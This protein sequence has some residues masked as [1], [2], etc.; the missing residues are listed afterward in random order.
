MKLKS[1]RK[2]VFY[3]ANYESRLGKPDIIIETNEPEKAWN[4]IRLANTA[5]KNNQAIKIFFISAGVEI[6]QITGVLMFSA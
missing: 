1:R 6:E 3:W 2:A 5:L 4:A